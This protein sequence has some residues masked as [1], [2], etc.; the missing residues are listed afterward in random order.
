MEFSPHT[1]MK[2]MIQRMNFNEND[3]EILK[4][5]ADWGLE[6]APEMARFFYDYLE[7][8][9]EMNT[10][11]TAVEGRVHRLHATFITWFQEMFLGI[12]DWDKQYA[13]RRWQIG[14]VHVRIGITPQHV[15]PAM[16][17][18]M[19]SLEEKRHESN[20]SHSL[21]QALNK[22]CMI[23]LTFIEQAYLE[24]STS[25]VMRETGWSEALFRRLVITGTK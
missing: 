9:E 22:I 17:T 2:L 6:I 12:D 25:A 10:I 18:V 3:K 21:K 14:L 1:F 7:K 20:Y 19:S 15:V 13:E 23:D 16:A 24:V 5:H 8:D 4:V 11:L